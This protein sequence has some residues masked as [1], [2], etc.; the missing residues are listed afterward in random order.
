MLGKGILRGQ[1]FEQKFFEQKFFEQKFFEQKFFEQKFFEQKFFKQKFFEQKFFEQKFFKQK[2]F[3]QKFFEKKFFEKKFFEKKVGPNVHMYIHMFP[4]GKLSPLGM[5]PC[6]KNWA[7]NFV[8][9][10]IYSGYKYLPYL[11]DIDLYL[12]T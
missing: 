4:A 6:E 1:F 3:E 2:F 9:K 8:S 10:P 7:S 5:Y 12:H 11:E